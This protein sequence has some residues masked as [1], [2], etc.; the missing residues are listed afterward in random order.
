M[1]KAV[2]RDFEATC[3]NI[4]S[5]DEKSRCEVFVH[6]ESIVIQVRRS[7]SHLNDILQRLRHGMGF[8]VGACDFDIIVVEINGTLLDIDKPRIFRGQSALNGA[9]FDG[10]KGLVADDE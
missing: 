9:V 6:C 1:C 5:G 10:Q 8:D 2:V 3:G 7:Q 4:G